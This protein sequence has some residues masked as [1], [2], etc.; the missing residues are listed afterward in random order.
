MYKAMKG[1]APSYVN[2]MFQTQES[3]YEMRDND[4]CVLPKY[5]TVSF[6]KNSIRYYGAKLWNNIPTTIKSSTSLNTF[7]SA[8]NKW[9]LTCDNNKIT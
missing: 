9:L 8:I 4:R 2:E 7:K 5:N 6:G 1:I 3:Q